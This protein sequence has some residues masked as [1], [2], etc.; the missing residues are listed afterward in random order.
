[1]RGLPLVLLS[2]LFAA[3]LSAPAMA[4]PAF[5][6][7]SFPNEDASTRMGINWVTSAED[8][9]FV[10]FGVSAVSENQVSAQPAFD[11]PGIGWMH[12]VELVGLQP[13]TRYK[14]RVG[15]PSGWSPEYTF[16]TAPNDGC[17]PVTFAAVGD[18]RSQLEFGPSPSWQGILEETMAAG[19]D[20]IIN[21]G[22]LV[23]TG[24]DIEQWSNW[25]VASD[26]VNPFIPHMP[27][28][29]N[30]DDGPGEGD[31]AHYNRL[32]QLPRNPVTQTED[33][34]H[35]VY[36][37][38]LFFALSTQTFQ[39]YTAQSNYVKEI[40]AQHPTKWK[41]VFFHHPVYTSETFGIGHEPN[42]KGQNQSL[43]PAFDEAGI[44][45]VI[46]GHNH[47]YERFEPLRYNPQ[48]PGQGQ[49]VSTYGN[50]P[51]DGRMYVISGGAGSFTNPLIT[52]GSGATGSAARS[53]AHH[54]VKVAVSGNTL[55]YSAIRTNTAN[56]SGAGVIETLTVSRP[57][58]DP[59]LAGQ[60]DADG[61][62]YPASV[63]CDDSD[64]TVNPGAA[65]V[66]GNDIDEDCD[67][68]AQECAVPPVDEDQDGSPVDSDCDD[69]DPERYP[70]NPEVECDGID[71]DCD[72]KELCQ[73]VETN[74]CNPP[75]PDAGA[76]NPDAA[77]VPNP[78]DDAGAVAP[79]ASET[80]ADLGPPPAG[81]PPASGCDCA[82]LSEND[83]SSLWLGLAFLLFVQVRRR[84]RADMSYPHREP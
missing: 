37:N 20:L 33:Y 45:M 51:N 79:D 17:T 6:K 43:G 16:K 62:N 3:G 14:Y 28:I 46:M 41:V 61:D 50:G 25:I 40:S 48:D 63:D 64:E 78:P 66:C 38:I 73:G 76:A 54:F 19:P 83:P 74:V 70:E 71:N 23:R 47:H 77:V 1:M 75:A 31:G 30:H 27:S 67:G 10:Q 80:P 42:E 81:A 72:C 13:N 53:A 49:V 36:N 24:D 57:G 35:F 29:G 22:D 26:T 59:C 9:G 65:E 12:E 55:T 21:S 44:D 69:Q 18:G 7:L 5:V 39:D 34:Y 52:A 15:N 68:T 4:Q 56:S 84:R 82:A 8:T 32:F 58:T 2:G 11:F 60:L